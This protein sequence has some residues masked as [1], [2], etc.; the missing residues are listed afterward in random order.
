[1]YLY[2]RVRIEKPVK[3]AALVTTLIAIA[4]TAELFGGAA[5]ILTGVGGIAYLIMVPIVVGWITVWY[6]R[7][8]GKEVSYLGPP[9]MQAAYPTEQTTEQHE[10]STKPEEPTQQDT[11]APGTQ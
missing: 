3:R 6:H 2:A 5:L 4:F 8:L 10:N 7:H 1:L 9:S 11:S